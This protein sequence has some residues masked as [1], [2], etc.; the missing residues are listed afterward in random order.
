MK[1]VPLQTA[2]AKVAKGAQDNNSVN[3]DGTDLNDLP[4]VV[5]YL[6]NHFDELSD[7]ASSAQVKTAMN[8]WRAIQEFKNEQ[9]VARRKNILSSLLETFFGPSSDVIVSPVCKVSIEAQKQN[10]DAD[11]QAMMAVLEAEMLA[12]IQTSG[13]VQ[14]CGKESVAVRRARNWVFGPTDASASD[15]EQRLKRYNDVAPGILKRLETATREELHLL[16]KILLPLLVV[17]SQPL[18]DNLQAVFGRL[19]VVDPL[20]GKA[21]RRK[22]ITMSFVRTH[23]LPESSN[24]LL[25]KTVS[26]FRTEEEPEPP[27][28][29]QANFT[30]AVEAFAQGRNFNKTKKSVGNLADSLSSFSSYDAMK[31]DPVLRRNLMR[32]EQF[33][34]TSQLIEGTSHRLLWYWALHCWWVAQ[35]CE[36]SM[37]VAAGRFLETCIIRC[38]A[39]LEFRCA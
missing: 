33:F 15:L 24:A 37:P 17:F 22:A 19:E 34:E 20:S 23:K 28:D 21:L 3:L 27:V 36:E 14:S 11:P 30:N 31:K 12:F 1:H 13:V 5:F 8:V 2:A 9:A 32:V 18:A 4:I 10:P 6:E 26:L 38:A 29:G 16:I 25:Q 39:A 7:A 35:R